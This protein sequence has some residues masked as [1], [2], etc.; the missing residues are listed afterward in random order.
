MKDVY[1]GLRP[2]TFA[3]YINFTCKIKVSITFLN[4]PEIVDNS[5]FG[6]HI[7]FY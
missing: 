1:V 5:Q 4:M 7:D 6:E 3:F 2:T